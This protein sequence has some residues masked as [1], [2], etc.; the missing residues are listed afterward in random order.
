VETGTPVV[1]LS[2]LEV[3]GTDTITT[4]NS[5]SAYRLTRHLL[6][7]GR[8]R[9]VFLGDP[10]SSTDAV[11]RWAGVSRALAEDGRQGSVVT[12]GF[13]V[14]A[15][16]GAALRLL[17]D[18]HPPEA[19]VCFNDEVALGVLLAAEELGLRVPED[20]AVTGWDDIMAARFTRPPLT[21]VR[22]PMRE[23]GAQAARLLDER[24]GGSRTE[25]VHRVLPTELVIRKSCGTGAGTS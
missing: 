17:A 11:E 22:Q 21:T 18:E 25:L 15:G 8:Q 4:E 13:D 3:P 20:V 5:T 10:A 19:L 6:D 12:C 2:R 1:L 7:N 16:R 24:T 14:D 9:V 23:L